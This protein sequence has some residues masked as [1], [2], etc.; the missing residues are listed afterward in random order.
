MFVSMLLT[1]TGP[2]L[3]AVLQVGHFLGELDPRGWGNPL[4]GDEGTG[5]P[6]Y[7]YRYLI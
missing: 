6:G 5:C 3:R 2:V 7:T 1:F 4:G